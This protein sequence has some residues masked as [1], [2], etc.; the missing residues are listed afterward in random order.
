[1]T[2]GTS[3]KYLVLDLESL[4]QKHR[5][6]P[7]LK[8]RLREGLLGISVVDRKDL[9]KDFRPEECLCLVDG[10][11]TLEWARGRGMAVLGYGPSGAGDQEME[12]LPMV[13]EDF[14]EVDAGFLLRVYQRHHQLPWTILDT[15]R[16]VIREVMPEDVDALYE[17]YGP[18]EITCYM[19]GL[20]EDRDSEEAYLR[21]YIAKMYRFYGYGMWVVIDKATGRLMGRAGLSHL[22]VEGEVQLE[23]GYVIAREYQRQGYGYEVCR[24]IL[25]YAEEELS[26]GS[27]HCLIQAANRPSIGLAEKLGF[28]YD[29][30]VLCNGKEMQRYSKILHF[31]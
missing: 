17:L 30:N 6:S 29:K 27:I 26:F 15:Q 20:K 19:E 16:C 4:R 13:V 14:D 23:L 7:A 11:K 1:M 21:A 3:L 24:G 10:P 9:P 2:T 31:S 25:R 18:K 22:E 8:Q 28:V 12:W 5:M